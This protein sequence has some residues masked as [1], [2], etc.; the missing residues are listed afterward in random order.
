MCKAKVCQQAIAALLTVII[1]GSAN[2]RDI[3]QQRI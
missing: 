2:Y 3:S 1:P